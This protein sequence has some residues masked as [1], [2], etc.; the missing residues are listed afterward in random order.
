MK[1]LIGRSNKKLEF[2]IVR[3]YFCGAYIEPLKKLIKS[4]EKWIPNKVST[5][6]QVLFIIHSKTHFQVPNLKIRLP[7]LSF[8]KYPNFLIGTYVDFGAKMN[9][10]DN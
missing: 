6:K 8:R 5:T 9:I 7:I 2:I 3:K 4:K 1:I 10:F